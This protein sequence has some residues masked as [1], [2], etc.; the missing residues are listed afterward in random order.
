MPAPQTSPIRMFT[1]RSKNVYITIQKTYCL[2][3]FNQRIEAPPT[4]THTSNSIQHE[5][6][7]GTAPAQEAHALL[8]VAPILHQ[9][10]GSYPTK[11]IKYAAT[12]SHP[13]PTQAPSTMP[14]L[15]QTSS[16]H[17]TMKRKIC[18]IIITELINPLPI[19]YE[20]K[21]TVVSFVGKK[22]LYQKS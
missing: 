3:G 10:C 22:A 5:W 4:T 21:A 20:I 9:Q 13:Q 8:A 1:S 16:L 17:P 18:F 14:I 2:F 7:L 19:S 12:Y 6:S 11:D 15:F